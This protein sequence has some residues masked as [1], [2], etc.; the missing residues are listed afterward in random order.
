[1]KTSSNDREH[2][3]A[4]LPGDRRNIMTKTGLPSYRVPIVLRWLKR[5]GLALNNEKGY[6]EPVSIPIGVD[7]CWK[8][9]V[10]HLGICPACRN[11]QQ[12]MAAETSEMA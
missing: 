5:H 12:A 1:M 2:V 10:F 6:W 7:L 4:S 3:Y 11:R 9:G 8:H